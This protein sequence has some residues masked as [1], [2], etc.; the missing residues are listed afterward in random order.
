MRNRAV[1]IPDYLSDSIS[2]LITL[3]A[4]GVSGWLINSLRKAS[5]ADLQEVVIQLTRRLDEIETEQKTFV[6]RTE[7]RDAMRDLKDEIGRQHESLAKQLGQLNTT[8]LNRR[9]S[10]HNG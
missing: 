8:L 3:I 2:S 4:G 1:S 6:T 10:T 7:F 9:S 5:R